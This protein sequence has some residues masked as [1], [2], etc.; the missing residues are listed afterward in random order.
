[1]LGESPDQSGVELGSRLDRIEDRL[2]RLLDRKE[3]SYIQPGPERAE[4]IDWNTIAPD[5]NATGSLASHAFK[6]MGRPRL[7][8][9]D[10]VASG[11]VSP[12]ELRYIHEK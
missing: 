8:F 9:E 5:Y 12:I 3:H 4:V 11:I 7:S 2:E 6:V 1:M 10:P